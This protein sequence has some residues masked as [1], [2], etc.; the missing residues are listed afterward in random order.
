LQ[1]LVCPLCRGFL[2]EDTAADSLRCSGCGAEYPLV[3]AIP[4]V[5]PHDLVDATAQ[6][7]AFFDQ[8][9]AEFETSRPHGTPPLY[10]RLLDEKFR[11]GVSELA[12][13]LKG[14][15]ALVVCGGSGMDAEFLAR[16]G[17]SVVTSDISLGAARRARERA[18]RYGFELEVVVA[19]ATRLPFADGTFNVVYVHDGL[20]HLEQPLEALGEMARVASNAVSVNEPARAGATALAIK[21]GLAL[22]REEAGNVVRRLTVQEIS[23]VLRAS[24]FTIVD[25]RRYAM[26]YRHNPGRVL[27]L[28]SRD[29]LLPLVDATLTLGN[30]LLGRFGNKLA[31]Q[32]VRASRHY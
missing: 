31:V 23:S 16:A 6:Q 24:G 3:D 14:S 2:A 26:L 15:R 20:H 8:E 22:E 12:S 9:D 30:N 18:A 10:G 11:R 4:V 7:A 29:R 17:A 27:R 25:A 28:L 32:A 5:V 1:G 13:L 21:L 19:D